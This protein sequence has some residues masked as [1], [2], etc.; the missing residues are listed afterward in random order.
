VVVVPAGVGAV[1]YL[2]LTFLLRVKEVG[3]LRDLVGKRL[4][5]PNLD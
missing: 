2:T 3:V 1:A 4:R 5:R